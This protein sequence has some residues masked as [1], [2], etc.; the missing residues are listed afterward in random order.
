MAK[1]EYFGEKTKTAKTTE[2][3]TKRKY[4]RRK[5]VARVGNTARIEI[6]RNPRAAFELGR[7]IAQH[8]T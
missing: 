5:V 6:P 8:T 1:K 7:M 2:P 4:T 3:K